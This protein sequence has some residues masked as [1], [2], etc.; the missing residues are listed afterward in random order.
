MVRLYRLPG[1]S[2]GSKHPNTNHKIK[3]HQ[4]RPDIVLQSLYVPE[5]PPVPAGRAAFPDVSK[6]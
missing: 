1:A 2:A 5:S 6:K 3:V 4:K